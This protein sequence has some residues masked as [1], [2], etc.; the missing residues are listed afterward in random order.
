MLDQA[1]A[2]QA[3][4]AQARPSQGKAQQASQPSQGCASRAR[5]PKGPQITPFRHQMGRRGTIWDLGTGILRRIPARFSPDRSHPLNLNFFSAIV[6]PPKPNIAFSGRVSKKS[7]K[8][9]PACLKW[10]PR[11]LGGPGALFSGIFC[12]FLGPPGP[13]LGG[14]PGAPLFSLSWAAALWGAPPV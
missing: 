4:Q 14:G 1:K 3:R 8:I 13:A 6:D 10:S 7:S 2:R 9:D 5:N 11:A 12:L